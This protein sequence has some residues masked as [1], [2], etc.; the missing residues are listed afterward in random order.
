[1]IFSLRS[2]GSDI[3][4]ATSDVRSPMAALLR[5]EEGALPVCCVNSAFFFAMAAAAS[6][7]MALIVEGSKP[8]FLL[9]PG[10]GS[11]L[12]SECREV[13]ILLVGSIVRSNDALISLHQCITAGS[14]TDLDRQL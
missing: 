10:E 13:S 14:W 11:G 8:E 5:L 7:N 9:L 3:D 1:M 6:G 4:G 12:P 2:L